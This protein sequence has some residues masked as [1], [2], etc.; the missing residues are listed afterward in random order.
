ME[1]LQQKRLR[2]RRALLEALSYNVDEKPKV[3]ND[4]QCTICLK[5]IKKNCEQLT[6]PC[7]HR[8][9]SHCICQWANF[10][11]ENETVDAIFPVRSRRISYYKEGQNI[12]S[13]PT[14]RD[15]FTRD[16]F[17]GLKRKKVIA[18]IHALYKGDTCIH[19]ITDPLEPMAYIPKSELTQENKIAVRWAYYIEA[20]NKLWRAGHT[21][22]WATTE[23]EGGH[24]L[25]SSDYSDFDRITKD[26]KRITGKRSPLKIIDLDDLQK[27]LNDV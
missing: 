11:N 27:L 21:N 10:K 17:D 13:C 15:E 16:I 8:Y 24:F 22:V 19:Y 3:F 14:C 1:S 6:L 2:E 9:H 25:L 12:F 23:E 7:G 4:G 5:R 26:G 20:L 18:K